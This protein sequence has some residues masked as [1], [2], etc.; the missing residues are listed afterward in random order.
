M[1][2]KQIPEI[3]LNNNIEHNTN[4]LLNSFFGK[5]QN[6]E[7]D[8]NMNFLQLTPDYINR[9]LNSNPKSHW[10]PPKPVLLQNFENSITS[11]LKDIA[12][13]TTEISKYEKKVKAMKQKLSNKLEIAQSSYNVIQRTL[14]NIAKLINQPS[15]SDALKKREDCTDDDW[16]DTTKKAGFLK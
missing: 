12:F 14:N 1:K 4:N 15:I 9:N 10:Q 16:D 5:K 6:S 13:L 11:Q 8:N 7:L 3:P 2:F